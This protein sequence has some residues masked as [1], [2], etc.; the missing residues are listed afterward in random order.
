MKLQKKRDVT[1]Q[2]IMVSYKGST[3]LWVSGELFEDFILPRPR[4][5]AG[6][7]ATSLFFLVI[8]NAGIGN[9]VVPLELL[10]MHFY[11]VCFVVARA[12]VFQLSIVVA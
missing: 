3:A 7:S 10:I 11:T 1:K 2:K 5:I 9:I 4:W 12:E 8:S 6:G